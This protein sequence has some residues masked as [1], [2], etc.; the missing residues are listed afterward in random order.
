MRTIDHQRCHSSAVGSC[1]KVFEEQRV[2]SVHG[3]DVGVE[4]VSECV[5]R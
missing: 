5:R 1:S 4:V 3:E 2:K